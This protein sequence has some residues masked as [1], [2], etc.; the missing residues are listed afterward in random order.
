MKVFCDKLCDKHSFIYAKH[1]ALTFLR[2]TSAIRERGTLHPL[3]AL[4]YQNHKTTFPLRYGFDSSCLRV[5]AP[6][7]SRNDYPYPLQVQER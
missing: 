3:T 7:F 2:E 4:Q 1:F 5:G 6:F